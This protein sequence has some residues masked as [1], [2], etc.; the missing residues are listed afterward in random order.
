MFFLFKNFGLNIQWGAFSR[1][2]ERNVKVKKEAG[3][4]LRQGQWKKQEGTVMHTDVT[5]F[6]GK[7]GA[8]YSS[9][10]SWTTSFHAESP[11]PKTLISHG[12][13]DWVQTSTSPDE[14][15]FWVQVSFK[16]LGESVICVSRK[17]WACIETRL[18]LRGR[19]MFWVFNTGP[20]SNEQQRV[21]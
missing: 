15:S 4:Q 14:I 19:Q 16:L 12:A 2:K 21:R 7:S 18:C 13:R 5:Y 10:Y 3:Q 11:P 17:P 20:L 9:L 1:W 6:F 8:P